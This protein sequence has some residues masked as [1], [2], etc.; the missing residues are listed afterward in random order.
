MLSSAHDTD[1][2]LIHEL[3]IE[4][5]SAIMSGDIDRWISLWISG[6]IEMQ[7][8]GA[9]LSGIEQIRAVS[10]PVMELFVTKI[11]ISPEDVRIF[12]DCAYSY[13]FYNYSI[14]P[15]E[16]GESI[17]STGMFLTIFEKQANGS[18]KIAISCFNISPLPKSFS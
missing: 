5:T 14:M 15:K 10:Q 1:V 17:N 11:T 6:G 13:G 12:G 3:W 2:T 9:R 4:Y 8:A 18:W 7:P 16:G